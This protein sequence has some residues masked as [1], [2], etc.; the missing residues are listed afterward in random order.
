M[1]YFDVDGVILINFLAGLTFISEREISIAL[2][3]KQVFAADS[4]NDSLIYKVD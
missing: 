3:L 2:I 4:K 1:F